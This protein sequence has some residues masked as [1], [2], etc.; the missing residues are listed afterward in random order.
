[1][2]LRSLPRG[3]S[4][5]DTAAYPSSC[6]RRA[7][8]LPQ[9]A[10]TPTCHPGT[11]PPP[12]FFAA[13]RAATSPVGCWSADSASAHVETCSN[14]ASLQSL[15][16]RA[17]RRPPISSLSVSRRLVLLSAVPP[18]DLPAHEWPSASPPLLSLCS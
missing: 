17:R 15:F 8:V 4:Y 5:P 10:L 3:G 13:P 2:L 18:C 14:T 16:A 7:V 9:P 12:A 6:R 11:L 1:M